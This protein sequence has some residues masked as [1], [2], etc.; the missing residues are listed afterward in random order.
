KE[1]LKEI[2]QKEFN[3]IMDADFVIILLPAG[4]GSHIELGI[5]LG[6]G[7]NIYLYSPDDEVNNLESTSTFYHLPQ[8]NQC[9]GSTEELIDTLTKTNTRIDKQHYENIYE[10]E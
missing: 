9:A 2:G 1:D 6:Q 3:A 5:A 10:G 8:I 4:K 7:K